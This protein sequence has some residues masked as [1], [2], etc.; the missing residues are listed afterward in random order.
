MHAMRRPIAEMILDDIG[1]VLDG[2][3]DLG[4]AVDL[5]QLDDVRH[6]LAV[7][8]RH[9]WFG[10]VYCQ[11]AQARAFAS[12]HHDSFHGVDPLV[13]G[14]R[15]A[16]GRVTSSIARRMWPGQGQRRTE[17][18]EPRTTAALGSWFLV[19]RSWVLRLLAQLLN[20]RGELR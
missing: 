16:D 14:W 8:D 11:R 12:G 17:N 10:T 15:L 20:P 3:D 9:H 13:C 18:Q 5:Q 4:D 2:D 7:D 1:E 6:H 19:L